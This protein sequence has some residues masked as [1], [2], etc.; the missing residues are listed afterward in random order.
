[1]NCCYDVLKPAE[2]WRVER[3]RFEVTLRVLR[4]DYKLFIRLK[5]CAFLEGIL[6]VKI[7][8]SLMLVHVYY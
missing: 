2:E 6:N 4:I 3:S 8:F 5:L 1:M 7:T